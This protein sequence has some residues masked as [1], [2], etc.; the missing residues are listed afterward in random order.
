M[1]HS[2]APAK[3][4]MDEKSTTLIW[5]GGVMLI[6]LAYGAIAIAGFLRRR[7]R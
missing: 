1:A 5:M 4:L 3:T 7:S 6:M 2:P